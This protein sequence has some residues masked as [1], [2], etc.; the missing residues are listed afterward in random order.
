MDLSPLAHSTYEN[1]T[2]I[3]VTSTISYDRLYTVKFRAYNSDDICCYKQ[4]TISVLNLL[5]AG[6]DDYGLPEE[7][8]HQLV[9]EGVRMDEVEGQV[10]QCV[11]V[12]DALPGSR[13]G[14]LALIHG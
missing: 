7:A 9:H 14:Y 1:S 8:R 5:K 12:V 4:F 3:Q 2:E 11:R 10:R 13:V 6:A